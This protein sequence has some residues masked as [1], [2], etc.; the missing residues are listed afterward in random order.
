[1]ARLTEERPMETYFTYLWF[2]EHAQEIGLG[3]FLATL[4]VLAWGLIVLTAFLNAPPPNCRDKPID[5][6]VSRRW[7]K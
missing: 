7:T 5:D 1:M 6:W 4:V 3:S 2:A